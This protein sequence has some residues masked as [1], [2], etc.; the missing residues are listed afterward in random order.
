MAEMPD[1]LADAI[2]KG[3]AK[4]KA[5]RSDRDLDY[6]ETYTGKHL[7]FMDPKPEDFD[8]NDIA[9][10]LANTCRWTGHCKF[11]AS[12][13]EHSVAVSKLCPNEPLAALLHDASEAYL[14][15]IASPIKP[16]LQN[17]RAIEDG[18]MKAI[19]IKF[20]FKYPLSM[21]IKMADVQQLSTEA[22][23]LIPSQGRPWAWD[24]WSPDH[25]RPNPMKGIKPQG[26]GP[27]MAEAMFMARF[28]ELTNE[29]V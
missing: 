8:I 25:V 10:A 28:K 20:G 24:V 14:T 3:Y 9:H 26:Y 6:I 27:E 19:A 13:A 29:V 12:V 15:D 16:Y 2:E 18:L 11:F 5:V 7:Y 23:H 22:Y 17:Y 21:E 4:D 1:H